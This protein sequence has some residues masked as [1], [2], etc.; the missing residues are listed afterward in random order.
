M[1]TATQHTLCKYNKS[2]SQVLTNGRQRKVNPLDCL[3]SCWMSLHEEVKKNI[4]VF[5]L[6]MGFL[7]AGYIEQRLPNRGIPPIWISTVYTRLLS[8]MSLQLQTN[9]NTYEYPKSCKDCLLSSCALVGIHRKYVTRK[10]EQT[11]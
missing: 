4:L 8:G 2:S 1:V 6:D 7:K 5:C 10:R 9:R 3:S 11:G